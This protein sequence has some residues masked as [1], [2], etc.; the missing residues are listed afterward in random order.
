[1]DIQR[2]SIHDG[3]GIRTTVF[4]KGCH[5]HCQWCHNPESQLPFPEVMFYQ[6]QCFGCGACMPLCR[7]NAHRIE[8]VADEG[9]RK[10][11]HTI[12]LDCCRGCEDM[13]RCAAV[14]PSLAIRLVGKRM[15]AEEVMTELRKD[16]DF[17]RQ[18]GGVTFSGGEPLLQLS[19]LKEILPKCRKE[20][21]HVCI[22]TTL[23][24][25][26]EQL[27]EVAGEIDLFLVDCKV[28]N[29]ERAV[30]YQGRAYQYMPENLRR[31]SERNIPVILRVPIAAGVNDTPEESEE[32]RRLVEGL[33]NIIRIDTFPVSS[34]GRSKYEALQRSMEW[35]EEK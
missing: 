3:P 16:K 25:A 20:G 13:E 7:R 15:S 5:L 4:L 28:L 1:M 22:D 17:Y 21:L 23:E 33:R 19:F 9:K 29:P 8:E 35:K 12:R 24:I 11:I 6:K 14:C 32:R 26:W 2:F 10:T 34:H 30:V 18:G 31:L 27:K